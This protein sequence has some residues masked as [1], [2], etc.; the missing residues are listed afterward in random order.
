[1]VEDYIFGILRKKSQ[2]IDK[3]DFVWIDRSDYKFFQIKNLVQ[4]II[5]SF[6]KTLFEKK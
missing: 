5:D 3:V 6:L 4:A 2:I 1:M